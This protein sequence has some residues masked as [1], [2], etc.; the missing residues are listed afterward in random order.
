M[1]RLAKYRELKDGGKYNLY[2]VTGDQTVKG[3]DKVLVTCKCGLTKEVNT[4]KLVLG[5]LIGCRS[6]ACSYG[7]RKKYETI[8]KG[9]THYKDN[10]YVSEAGEVYSSNKGYLSLAGRGGTYS[11]Y[12]KINSNLYLHR[13]LAETFIPPEPGRD[14]VNHI[15]GNTF[16]NELSNLEW[17]TYSE[18]SLHANGHTDYKI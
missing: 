16:N 14:I 10:L 7:R 18:N 11:E 6:C 8:P 1:G 13:M 2:T 5:Y 4:T 9:F 3:T 12:V 17:V 15:D